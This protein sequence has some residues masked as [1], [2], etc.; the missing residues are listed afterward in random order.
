MVVT[1][2]EFKTDFGKY[3]DMFLSEDI[4][5]TR[6]NKT[7]AKMV[8]PNVSAVDAVSGLLAGKLLNDYDVQALREERLKKMRLMIDTNIF[9]D[10]LSEREPFYTNSKK[11]KL[12]KNY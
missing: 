8:N 2:A 10:V 11:G 7:I 12:T 9:L 3:L 6:N 5:N 1:A 4:F